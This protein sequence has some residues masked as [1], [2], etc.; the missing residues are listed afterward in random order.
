MRIIGSGSADNTI[1]LWDVDPEEA[2][3]KTLRSYSRASHL[4]AYPTK[5]AHIPRRCEGTNLCL[6]D[7]RAGRM[8]WAKAHEEQAGMTID[9]PWTMCRH[10]SANDYSDMHIKDIPI[11]SRTWDSYAEPWHGSPQVHTSISTN[12]SVGSSRSLEQIECITNSACCHWAFD[13]D[14]WVVMCSS[15]R[16]LWVPAHVR[17]SIWH[18]A[19]TV[20][21]PEQ[22]SLWVDLNH[23]PIGER[24]HHCYSPILPTDQPEDDRPLQ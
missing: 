15:R 23:A 22:H 20:E 1:R 8:E 21:I 17:D 13:E 4:L 6:W 11:S 5:H 3:C 7:A 2:T 9:M 18:P 24:W 19:G 12:S 14:G 16:L 10:P